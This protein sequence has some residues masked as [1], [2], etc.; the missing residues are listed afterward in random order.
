MTVKQFNAVDTVPLPITMHEWY[1][2]DKNQ[3]KQETK[4]IVFND[5]RLH[6]HHINVPL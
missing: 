1:P 4:T 3:V 2:H 5:S 6:W